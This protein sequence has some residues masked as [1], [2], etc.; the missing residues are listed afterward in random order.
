MPTCSINVRC[1]AINVVNCYLCLP[2]ESSYNQTWCTVKHIGK[3]QTT[4]GNELVI[5]VC[6]YNLHMQGL[7]RK[8]LEENR[9]KYS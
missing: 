2:S 5:V 3:Q 7:V 6:G 9:D 1:Q 8:W 4:S